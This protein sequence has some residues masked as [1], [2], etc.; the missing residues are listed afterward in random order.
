MRKPGEYASAAMAKLRGGPLSGCSEVLRHGGLSATVTRIGLARRGGAVTE[1]GVP[2]KCRVL[3]HAADLPA[4]KEGDAV[5]LGNA[6]RVVTS[7]AAG[8]ANALLAVGLSDAF[9][10]R[11]VITRPNASAPL[12]VSV[13]LADSNPD[14]VNVGGA[15]RA[16]SWFVWWPCGARDGRS[17]P[18]R[19]S[20]VTFPDRPDLPRLF[21]QKCRR[22]G[23]L[24]RATCTANE[25]AA[26]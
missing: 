10:V 23:G 11:A 3:A 13:L 14:A 6:I 19:G 4:L 8:P 26:Q 24:F 16:E 2:E 7:C 18:P 17:G 22:V 15:A 25:R 9:D 1:A 12:R 20:S 5:E 21:V